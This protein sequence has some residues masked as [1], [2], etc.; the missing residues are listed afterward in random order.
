MEGLNLKII[1]S[2]RHVF[3]LEQSE[4]FNKYMRNYLNAV[5]NQ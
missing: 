1:D 4:E 2:A 5:S 3:N